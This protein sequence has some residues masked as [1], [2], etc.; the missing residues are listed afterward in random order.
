[1]FFILYI[2]YYYIYY[3]LALSLRRRPNCTS[4]T[5]YIDTRFHTSDC[6]SHW[7]KSLHTASYQRVQVKKLK[8]DNIKKETIPMILIFTDGIVILAT[9]RSYCT[10]YV[11]LEK[12]DMLKTTDKTKNY[13]TSKSQQDNEVARKGI[14]IEQRKAYKYVGPVVTENGRMDRRIDERIGTGSP[15]R[16]FISKKNTF[17]IKSETPKSVKFE[18]T[19]K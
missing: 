17:L 1:M 16:L 14:E 19:K 4:N 2:L 6:L 13:G 8:I 9:L 12:N 7:L 3:T 5:A 18:I 15:G 11:E 10:L